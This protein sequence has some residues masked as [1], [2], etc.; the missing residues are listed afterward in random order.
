MEDRAKA[1]TNA[2]PMS[3]EERPTQI[4]VGLFLLAGL[5]TVALMV[6]YFG[7]LGEGF[8]SYYNLRAEFANASGLLRGG[9]VLLAGAKVGRVMDSPAILPDMRGVY[10]ELRILEQVKIPVGSQFSIGSSGLLGDKY[11]QIILADGGGKAGYIEPGSTVQ[12]VMESG[13]IAGMADSAGTLISDLRETVGNINGVVKKLDSTVLS[14]QELDSISAT[15]RNLQAA[16]AKIET[17]VAEASTAVQSG[18]ETMDSAKKAAE[19]LQKTLSAMQGLI[20]QVRSGKGVL[21]TLISNRE[22][23][24]N[25]RALIANLRKH[26]VLWYKDSKTTPPPAN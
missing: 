21:G 7:R 12:G 9:E 23:A 22:M 13:G 26:G 15:I 1:S 19:E 6:V 11:V 10:V 14:K 20:E 8:S 25:L 18:K 2:R 24:D 3:S 16:S 5:V 17:T 4:K